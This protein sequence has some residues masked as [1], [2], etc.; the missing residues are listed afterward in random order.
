MIAT[1]ETYGGI[2]PVEPAPDEQQTTLDRDFLD[3]CHGAIAELEL[4]SA[5][6][7]KEEL[8][9][10]SAIWGGLLRRDFVIP[11]ETLL[12]R[13]ICWKSSNGRAA[14]AIAVG[15]DVTALRGGR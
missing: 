13:L 12:N 15:Q 9:T 7:F 6:N 3:D 8:Q 1:S 4:D 14:I 2:P 5:W 10:R 11:G